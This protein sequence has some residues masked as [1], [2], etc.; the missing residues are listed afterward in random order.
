M[1]FIDLVTDL[2]HNILVK[3]GSVTF[4]F[5]T[6]NIILNYCILLQ[7]CITKS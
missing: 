6:N 3:K 1:L 5:T 2:F 7:M 4:L